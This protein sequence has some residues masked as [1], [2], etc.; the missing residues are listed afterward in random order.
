MEDRDSE[1]EEASYRPSL[2]HTTASARRSQAT[3]ERNG[4]EED[5]DDSAQE[6]EEDKDEETGQRELA[7][8]SK[9]PPARQGECDAPFL[10]LRV[11]TTADP[12]WLLRPEQ[13]EEAAYA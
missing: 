5:E 10:R 6:D 2:S 8:G 13:C 4:T 11:A 9:R 3:R 7:V 1:D 12:P